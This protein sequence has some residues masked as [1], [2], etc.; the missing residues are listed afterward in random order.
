[1]NNPYPSGGFN[2]FTSNQPSVY[3]TR[4]GQGF[5][6]T[7]GSN[8]QTDLDSAR[9]LFLKQFA[10]E[11]LTSYFQE[12]SLMGL[13]PSKTVTSGK[14][15]DFPKT[16]ISS[17]EYH[18]AGIQLTG[19]DYPT[20]NVTITADAILESNHSI[21][22]LDAYLSHF[23][24]QAPM[25]MAMGQAMANTTDRNKFRQIVKAARE[26]STHANDEFPTGNVLGVGYGA[27]GADTRSKLG[28]KTVAD[29]GGWYD[30]L[31]YINA[32]RQVNIQMFN[33]HIP[34]SMKKYCFVDA[35]VFDSIKYTYSQGAGFIMLNADYRSTDAGGIS[36]MEN[37]LMIDG[38]TIMK[39]INLP[40]HDETGV[41]IRDASGFI[42]G[43]DNAGGANRV[44]NRIFPKYRG[45]YLNTKAVIFCSGAICSV[46]YKGVS[47][48]MS[49]ETDRLMDLIVASSLEGH[50]T[51]RREFAYE[52]NDYNFDTKTNYDNWIDHRTKGTALNSANASKTNVLNYT[53]SAGEKPFRTGAA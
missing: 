35:E 28:R 39:A 50:G 46:M 36:G 17:A 42:S 5:E 14:S 49:R 51:V 29:V 19:N 1:M 7:G 3:P 20:G 34:L 37:M 22:D 11:V 23:D 47:F 6:R 12:Q 45:N 48:E 33:N 53:A 32:I 27:E 16:G 25:A 18:E 26:V 4:F 43:K 8:S 52:L 15:F 44:G 2:A 40:S 21:Y 38:I 30:G 13:N 10:G 9:T 24:I 31:A 41:A